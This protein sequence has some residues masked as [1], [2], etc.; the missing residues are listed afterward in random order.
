MST[1]L[2]EKKKFSKRKYFTKETFIKALEASHGQLAATA[3]RLDCSRMTV[4]RY[5]Q[6]EEMQKLREEYRQMSYVFTVS[7]L[8]EA[9]E[10]DEEWA[11]KASLAYHARFTETTSDKAVL[12]I[13]VIE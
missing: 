9:V 3:R 12:K 5:M 8:D 4:W 13:K 2:K 11:I 10:R 6:S 1:D 7:K